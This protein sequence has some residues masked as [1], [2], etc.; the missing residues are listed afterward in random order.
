MSFGDSLD[1]LFAPTLTAHQRLD[2]GESPL[3]L[4]QIFGSQCIEAAIGLN[5]FRV[6]DRPQFGDGS[7]FLVL[8]IPDVE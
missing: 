6:P 3:G 2:D 1:I 5:G 8:A 4:G 7:H